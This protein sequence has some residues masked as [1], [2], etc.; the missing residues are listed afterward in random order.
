MHGLV[1]AGIKQ[2][3]FHSCVMSSILCFL[4]CKNKLTLIGTNTKSFI[5]DARHSL[6]KLS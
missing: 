4:L 5:R 6:C 3:C 1:S 2:H